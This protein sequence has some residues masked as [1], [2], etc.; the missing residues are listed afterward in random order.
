MAQGTSSPINF[1]GQDLPRPPHRP[2]LAPYA[3][4]PVYDFQV[5]D[6]PG[7][8][9]RALEFTPGFA[10]ARPVRSTR[11]G[12]G[13]SK[14][15]KR[16]GS[17]AKKAS[18]KQAEATTTGVIQ[19][20]TTPRPLEAQ[21]T[22]APDVEQ[23]TTTTPSSLEADDPPQPQTL[24]R[25]GEVIDLVSD[26]EEVQPSR[27]RARIN[28]R[29]TTPPIAEI[30][31]A[32]ISQP[33]AIHQSAVATQ[34][35]GG[36]SANAI[37]IED[38]DEEETVPAVQDEEVLDSVENKAGTQTL[39]ATQTKKRLHEEAFDAPTELVDTPPAPKKNRVDTKPSSA[40]DNANITP[41]HI[42]DAKSSQEGISGSDHPLQLE[43]GS[44]GSEDIPDSVEEGDLHNQR[45]DETEGTIIDQSPYYDSE[46]NE[47]DQEELEDL[48]DD[49]EF[50]PQKSTKRANKRARDHDDSD[51]DEY[52]ES[53]RKK[54]NKTK[55]E[56]SKALTRSGTRNEQ[57]AR[58]QSTQASEQERSLSPDL[59]ARSTRPIRACKAIPFK[60]L[61]ERPAVK[62]IRFDTIQDQAIRD[63]LL[64]GESDIEAEK[65][66]H[67]DHIDTVTDLIEAA[68]RDVTRAFYTMW[69]QVDVLSER[70][71]IIDKSESGKARAH[72]KALK[73]LRLA[74][75]N[76]QWAQWK[77]G[78][79]SWN[80]IS[81]PRNIDEPY[82]EFQEDLARKKGTGRAVASE[83][84]LCLKNGGYAPPNLRDC[85][86]EDLR[87]IVAAW[88]ESAPSQEAYDAIME[89]R[90]CFP[91]TLLQ[92]LE[93]VLSIANGRS[94]FTR[95]MVHDVWDFA[96]EHSG[97]YY[98]DPHL[99]PEKFAAEIRKLKKKF[100]GPRRCDTVPCSMNL[101][102]VCARHIGTMRGQ[103]K[104]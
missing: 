64:I 22:K 72:Y 12:R 91:N 100:R 57:A 85:M 52:E 44:N 6:S 96:L 71:D 32:H 1:L 15:P 75:W 99:E 68:G 77:Y 59:E 49:E 33:T 3:L 27:K 35:E 62:Y 28:Q 19:P 5:Y 37:V 83:Y 65:E 34:E 50:V 7:L 104:L 55:A 9:T 38:D 93:E 43:S 60:R 102:S 17:G 46:G 74:E 18:E 25:K 92:P 39:P 29:D 70:G 26:D 20:L 84:W 88:P 89:Y 16:V 67:T 41:N 78:G 101:W 11:F 24:K 14:S 97:N 47:Q 51:S 66:F 86:R 13:A 45:H 36:S 56:L 98:A 63:F 82:R 90:I 42:D 30:N 31:T 8:F 81:D 48:G 103:R 73:C 4:N 10:P 23:P 53:P 87:G 58:K 95:S 54:K 40:L 80:P 21:T 2:T 94:D 61:F 69:K 76:W 79:S